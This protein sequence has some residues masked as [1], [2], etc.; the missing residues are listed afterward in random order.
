[1]F[2]TFIC[3]VYDPGTGKVVIANGGHCR[4]VL[5]RSGEAPAWAVKNLGTA[6]G[7][8]EG[9]TFER[10][11]LTLNPGDSLVFYTDGVSEAFN[12]EDECYGDD[13]LIADTAVLSGQSAPAFTAGLLQKVHAFAN[14]APQ[15][16]DIAIMTLKIDPS[17]AS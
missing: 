12:P 17:R 5:L 4:P 6:L 16:D 7:F 15:S 14:G 11:E 9:L 8:D 3:A 2:V 10:T 13:R 1:M